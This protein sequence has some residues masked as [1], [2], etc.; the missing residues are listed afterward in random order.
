M[1]V[2]EE[3]VDTA[4]FCEAS[5]NLVK[6]F[7]LF[8]NPAFVVVQNDITGNIAVSVLS[9]HPFSRRNVMRLKYTRLCE[10]LG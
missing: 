7:G 10:Q 5:E 6:I 8:G 1:P 9:E 2:T 3:G 4:S